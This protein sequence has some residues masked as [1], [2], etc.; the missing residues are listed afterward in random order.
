MNESVWSLS[1]NPPDDSGSWI[2]DGWG[3]WTKTPVT[4]NII[5]T[6][7]IDDGWGNVKLLAPL[8]PNSTLDK[9]TID[10]V[11]TAKKEAKALNDTKVGKFL[12][13]VLE[14]G[15]SFLKLAVGFGLVKNP[16]MPIS[17]ENIDKTK[18]QQVANSGELDRT[19]VINT[20]SP[21][22]P[23]TN[24][25]Y[26]GIDFSNPLTWVV[27]AFAI[28]GLYKLFNQVPVAAQPVYQQAKRR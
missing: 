18:L 9:T 4:S 24:S 7:Y 23:K 22:P 11:E 28:W 17:Y 16:S 1:V 15:N 10:A 3:N 13:G 19:I 6:G 12:N 26:F 20:P 8:I 14:F 21:D 25:T 27:V 5:P 2:D